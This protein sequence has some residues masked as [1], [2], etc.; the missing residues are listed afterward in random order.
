MVDVVNGFTYVGAYISN[1]LFVYQMAEGM[2]VK[3]KTV[4]V[5]ILNS[6][7]NIQCLHF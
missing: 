4:L 2:S 6:L 3:A 5:Y 7:Q 1:R